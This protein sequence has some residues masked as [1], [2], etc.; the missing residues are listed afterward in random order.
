MCIL[1]E[2]AKDAPNHIAIRSK[3]FSLTYAELDKLVDQGSWKTSVDPI[4][5]LFVAWR[6]NCSIFPLNPKNPREPPNI[7]LPYASLLLYTSGSSGSPKI[8]ILTLDALLAN[9]NSA[10]KALDLK[11]G[12]LWKL[13]LPLYH[14]SGIG[15]VLRCVLARATLVLDDHPDITH[16]SC[17][18]THLYRFTPVYKKLKC[19]LLGGAP[20]SQI[21]TYLPIMTTYGLTEMGS[22]VTLDG[23]IL[24]HAQVQLKKDGEILVKGTSLFSGYYSASNEKPQLGWFHT[25]DL[26]KFVDGKLLIIGR[27]DWMF[28]SGGENIQPEEIEKELL[29]FPE[30]VEAVIIPI[31]DPEFG[32]RP[33]LAIRATQPI[34][35][36]EI[37]SRLA[38]KLPKFKI[39]IA[40]YFIDDFIKE[41]NL[42]LNRFILAQYIKNQLDQNISG[43]KNAAYL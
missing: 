28:I 1:K 36:R 14:V 24:P 43:Q 4:L 13:T 10:I 41:D 20:M 23:N 29:Q 8:A 35:L 21:P 40:L 17:V 42:K 26:G 11:A 33:A 34:T 16:I 6:K 25:K 3:D 31:D 7:K 39:P 18:P 38:E 37:Q 12:D 30:I 32:K 15:T 2:A 19:V 27:K 22:M 9:A 5:K